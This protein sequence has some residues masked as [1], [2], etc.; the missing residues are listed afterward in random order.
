MDEVEEKELSLVIVSREVL[1]GDFATHSFLLL[2]GLFGERGLLV[3]FEGVGGG[4]ASLS[5][6]KLSCRE[7]D[8]LPLKLFCFL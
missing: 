1:L 7:T 8:G 2:F 4:D 6:L 3:A 5:E